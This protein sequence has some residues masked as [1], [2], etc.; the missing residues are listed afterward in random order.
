MRA[1]TFLAVAA[2]LLI[3]GCGGG[4]DAASPG[5]TSSAGRGR[6]LGAVFDSVKA[7]D[8]EK[9]QVTLPI[10]RGRTAAGKPTF[11]IVTESSD[12]KDALRRGVT[13]AP[14]LEN[15]LNTKAV[16]TVTRESGTTVF[17]GSVDFSPRLQL[18]PNAATGFPPKRFRPGSVGDKKYSPLITAGDGVVLNA[19]QIAN[20]SGQGD[21]VVSVDRQAQEA[22]LSLFDGFVSG[23]RNLYL[24]T[25]GSD[26]LLAS[27]EST[28]Y[29]PNLAS[30][31]G[32]GSNAGS[33]ARS[34]I[35]PIVNGPRGKGNTQRQGL[36]SALLGQGQPLNVEQEAAGSA[37]YS[38]LWDVTPVVWTKKAIKAGKRK[39]LTSAQGI[40]RAAK[41]GDV[42]SLGEKKANPT[43]GGLKAIGFVSDC[44]IVSIG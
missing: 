24:R 41:A 38:P 20:S 40:A 31:P 12:R 35:S 7:L 30:A 10:S 1:T 15:A 3:A 29:A 13:Y 11:F 32:I 19:P 18:V 33:S 17:A 5:A 42:T 14:K 44:P 34:A 16:Q 39:R 8:K 37:G 25:D 28:T 22:T 4:G 6:D 23:A 36:E 9:K 27:L 2:P 43:L 26:K 21:Y